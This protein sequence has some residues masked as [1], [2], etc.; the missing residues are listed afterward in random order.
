MGYAIEIWEYLAYTELN[1]KVLTRSEPIVWKT[2]LELYQKL[3][4]NQ[5]PIFLVEPSLKIRYVFLD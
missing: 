5:F 4:D 2:Q 1:P 3:L